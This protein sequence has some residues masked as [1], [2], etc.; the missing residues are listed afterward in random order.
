MM[1]MMM[2]MPIRNSQKRDSKHIKNGRKIDK[3]SE[4][5]S[6]DKFKQ[7]RQGWKYRDKRQINEKSQKRVIKK[8]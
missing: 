2:K 5:S 1:K 7:V 6:S 3:S 8:D 4:M